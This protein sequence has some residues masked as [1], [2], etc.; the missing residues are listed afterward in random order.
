MKS[1]KV[2][3]GTTV[4]GLVFSSA[5]AACTGDDTVFATD[6]GSDA[7]FDV[8]RPD[9]AVPEPERDGGSDARSDAAP[10][11]DPRVLVT[12]N[13]RTSSELV[14]VNLRTRAVDGKLGFPG[15]IGAT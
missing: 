5:F 9:V 4:C 1:W 8:F 14:A 13:N 6:S 10:T 12:I 7:T 11:K 3:G 2:L 15:F